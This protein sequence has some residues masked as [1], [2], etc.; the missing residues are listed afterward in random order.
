[1]PDEQQQ[2]GQPP[3]AAIDSANAEKAQ[4]LYGS[5]PALPERGA[6]AQANA[7]YVEPALK[8]AAE[9]DA[10]LQVVRGE[11]GVPDPDT[12]QRRGGREMVPG[13]YAGLN[14]DRALDPDL[15]ANVRQAAAKEVA[16]IA[17]D[18]GVSRHELD[19]ALGVARS[20]GAMSQEQFQSMEQ[21]AWSALKSQ[22]G[23]GYHERLQLARKLVAGNSQLRRVLD[24]TGLGSHPRVVV[25]LCEAA[26]RQRVAGRLK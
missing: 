13:A 25:A 6:D 21:D 7:I 3:V 4:R 26:Q 5:E 20:V 17:A 15:P 16:Q 22:Y 12:L 19:E 8:A 24:Q 23:E 2:V 11:I 9:L 1:M 14:V 18:A 10:G